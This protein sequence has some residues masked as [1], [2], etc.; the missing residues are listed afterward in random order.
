M[1]SVES[2]VDMETPENGG[3]TAFL[4]YFPVFSS[5]PCRLVVPRTWAWCPLS[6]SPRS[7]HTRCSTL[8]RSRSPC[9]SFHIYE[10]L[11]LSVLYSFL[12]SLL[13]VIHEV[14]QQI[15]RNLLQYLLFLHTIQFPTIGTHLFWVVGFEYPQRI[16]DAPTTVNTQSTHTSNPHEV[17]FSRLFRAKS[18]RYRRFGY[19]ASMIS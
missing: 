8:S 12:F 10:K 16:N 14:H 6:G 13:L 18:S 17:Q 15:T 9:H 5:F 7:G 4:S 1:M 19:I 2:R 3:F 11:F